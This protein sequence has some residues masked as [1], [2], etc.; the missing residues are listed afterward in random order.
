[1]VKIAFCVYVSDLDGSSD[2]GTF[3]VWNVL[4]V[5]LCSE[6]SG[7]LV[8]GINVSDEVFFSIFRAESNF[9]LL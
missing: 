1:V 5:V 3:Y 2:I 4:I 6:T 8:D 9:N 7:S